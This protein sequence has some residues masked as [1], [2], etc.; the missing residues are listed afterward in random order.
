MHFAS[1]PRPTLLDRVPLRVALAVAYSAALVVAYLLFAL[2]FHAYL[3]HALRESL[4]SEIIA[5]IHWV[6]SYLASP[7][8][9]TDLTEGQPD[10]S[11]LQRR[12]LAADRK[13]S[14]GVYTAGGVPLFSMGQELSGEPREGPHARMIVSEIELDPE[15]R[16]RVAT[17][18]SDR[19]RFHVAAPEGSIDEALRNTRWVLLMLAPICIVV[20]VVGGWLIAGAAL[21]PVK[22][23]TRFAE[24]ISG[25]QLDQRIPVRAAD[26]ELGRLVD[27]FNRMVERLEASF[28]QINEFS[29][30]VAHELRTPLTLLRGEAELAM[31]RDRS[32]ERMRELAAGVHEEAVR[33]GRIVDDM[34]TLARADRG[35]APLDLADVDVATIL[36]DTYEDALILAAERDI[37]VRLGPNDAARIRGDAARL[38]QLLR[39]LISNAVR[40]TDAGG[41]IT[42]EGRRGGTFVRIAVEDTGVGIAPEH[43]PRIF[44]RFYRV[45]SGRSRD[46]GGA[47]LGLA[48]ARWIAEAHGGSIR[49]TSEPGKGS[50]FVVEL[51]READPPAG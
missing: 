46:R 39:V 15:H 38:R 23:V 24:R 11:V 5:E 30:N 31:S 44:D 37:E 41:S 18:W 47:G 48:L 36:Q 43:L 1:R 17:Q 19:Y 32:P 25:S 45:D 27:A 40:Y 34:L 33:M 51:P 35:Q 2:V 42:I 28:R 49:A 16:L 6:D 12:F 22:D 4:D 7:R 26:D 20:A 13:Y 3:G 21:R 9:S 14:V 10:W 50:R 8:P 29:S